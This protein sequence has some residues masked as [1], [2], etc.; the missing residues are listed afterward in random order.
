M[1]QYFP[2]YTTST[3]NIKVKLD[4]SNYVTKDD[5]TDILKLED[6]IKENEKEASFNRG[7]FITK[8]KV[9]LFMSARQNHLIMV[10]YT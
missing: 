2:S 1:S 8:I 6:K 4:L 3:K 10:I 7:F 9:I 5:K